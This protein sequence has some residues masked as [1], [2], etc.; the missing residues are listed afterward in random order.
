M[1]ASK[2]TGLLFG[3]AKGATLVSMKIGSPFPDVIVGIGYAL[4]HIQF[5]GRQKNSVTSI[6]KG[7]AP[8]GEFTRDQALATSLG[9][10]AKRILDEV[11]GLGVPVVVAASN[12]APARPNIDT[13]P[14]VLE[15]PGIPIIN[16]GGAGVGRE[17]RQLFARWEPSFRL[18]TWYG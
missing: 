4:R 18:R 11:H 3:L 9:R 2:A 6:S 16:V 10:A 17:S 15:G 14:S 8:A 5:H 7:G 13:V 1:C 12:F